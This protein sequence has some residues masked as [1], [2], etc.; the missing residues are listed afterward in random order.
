MSRTCFVLSHTFC[1]PPPS[2]QLAHFRR[3]PDGWEC[4]E[5]EGHVTNSLCR[6]GARVGLVTAF[7]PVTLTVF[8]IHGAR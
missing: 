5:G 7:S 6:P 3:S 8:P 4:G 2:F 1:R